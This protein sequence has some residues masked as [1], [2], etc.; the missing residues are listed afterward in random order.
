MTHRNISRQWRSFPAPYDACD[1]RLKFSGSR[2]LCEGFSCAGR[3]GRK[4]L[5]G[6][7]FGEC[8]SFR[9]AQPFMRFRGCW[10]YRWPTFERLGCTLGHIYGYKWRFW[11][12]AL[13]AR[14]TGSSMCPKPARPPPSYFRASDQWCTKIPPIP[15]LEVTRSANMFGEEIPTPSR[16]APSRF[17]CGL[18]L[19][20]TPQGC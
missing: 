3:D 17:L 16:P 8:G 10:V 13:N 11:R 12:A 6:I 19:T 14:S 4:A 18:C 15:T 1:S 2:P 9:G 7:T 20:W 5:G